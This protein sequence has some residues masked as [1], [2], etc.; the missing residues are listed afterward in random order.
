MSN[1]RSS[2]QVLKVLEGYVCRH[3]RSTFGVG[4]TETLLRT[5]VGWQAKGREGI[6]NIGKTPDY[7]MN[8]WQTREVEL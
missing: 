1:L 5:S 6:E 2:D 4:E 7:T 8:G 3:L